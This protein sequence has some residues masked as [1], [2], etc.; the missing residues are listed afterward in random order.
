M[1][2]QLLLF[3]G[4]TKHL[5]PCPLLT[6]RSKVRVLSV[7]QRF[8]ALNTFVKQE[9]IITKSFIE[10]ILRKVSRMTTMKL[11]VF[12]VIFGAID[13][14]VLAITSERIEL[15]GCACA[16]IEALEEW[17]GWIYPDDVWGQSEMGRNA[18]NTS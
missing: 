4:A 2:D 18:A 8:L 15:E 3:L 12:F 11:V 5:S 9:R 17:N 13:A 6:T 16:Q 10:R 7:S 1:P 14:M